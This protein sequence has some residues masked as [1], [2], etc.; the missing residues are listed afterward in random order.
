MQVNLGRSDS[1]PHTL[2]RNRKMNNIS[3]EVQKEITRIREMIT[4]TKTLLPNGQ[5]NFAIYEATVSA[6]EKAVR[7]QDAVALVKILPE[8]RC[9]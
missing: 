3:E 7:E 6:A 8:L 1:T 9:M 5:G 4:E 2:G